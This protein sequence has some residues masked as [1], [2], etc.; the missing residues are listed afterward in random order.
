[1]SKLE[2][3]IAKLNEELKNA[4][5]KSF[6]KPIIEYLITRCKDDESLCEDVIQDKKTW[7]GCFDYIYSCAKKMAKGKTSLGVRE[8]TVYK[9]AE[10]YYHAPVEKTASKKETAKPKI[11]EKISKK[12]VKPSETTVKKEPE[13]NKTEVQKPKEEVKVPK[14]KPDKKQKAEEKMQMSLF[15]FI[16]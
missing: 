8:D 5:D 3:A 2:N 11:P 15:D 14:K 4:S 9:W 6:A 13:E 12:S 7:K 10:D 1:M 16:G